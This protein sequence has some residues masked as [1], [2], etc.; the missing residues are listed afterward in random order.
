LIR[1]RFA[2]ILRIL[3]KSVHIR[4]NFITLMASP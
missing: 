3:Y 1:H 4:N 2:G